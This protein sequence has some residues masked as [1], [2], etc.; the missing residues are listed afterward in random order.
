MRRFATMGFWFRDVVCGTVPLPMPLNWTIAPLEHTVV[1]VSESVVTLQDVLAF[2]DAL[3]KAG[4]LPY[5]KIIDASIGSLG[6]TDAEIAQLTARTRQ[7]RQGTTLGA[8]AVVTVSGRKAG[9]SKILRA[10]STVDR[11]LRIFDNIHDARRWLDT[12]PPVR[13]LD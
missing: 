4:A 12:R 2:Y 7:L 11:P 1:C 6:L 3:E 5:R 10:L 9:L 13:R 8:M